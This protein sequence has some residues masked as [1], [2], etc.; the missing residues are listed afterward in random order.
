[1][2]EMCVRARKETTSPKAFVVRFWT[3]DTHL[4][5]HNTTDKPMHLANSSAVSEPLSTT[6]KVQSETLVRGNFFDLIRLQ[7]VMRL[8]ELRKVALECSGK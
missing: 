1:M 3:A 4:S 2:V 6:C 8:H 7:E 5:L